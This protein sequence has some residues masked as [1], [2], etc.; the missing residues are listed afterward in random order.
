MR[1]DFFS[2]FLIILL[3]SAFLPSVKSQPQ[4]YLKNLEKNDTF[5]RIPTITLKDSVVTYIDT[6]DYY[7]FNVTLTKPPE[8]NILTFPLETN[9]LIFYYQPPLNE[10]WSVDGTH[11]D[12]VNATH[13]LF[14]GTVVA[15]R[16]E[17]V[18]GSYAVYR[19]DGKT[20]GIYNTGKL[21]HIYTPLIIDAE[22]KKVW[23]ELKLTKT[24]LTVSIDAKF[25][26]SAIY[27]VVVDPTFGYTSIGGSY[28]G[29][30][31]SYG[32]YGCKFTSPSDIDEITS[33]TVYTMA[34]SAGTSL[35]ALIYSDNAGAPNA[36][37][38]TFS[39]ETVP[40]GS[41]GWVT[42]AGSFSASPATVYWLAILQEN[43][44][45]WYYDSGAS[46]QTAWNWDDW[47]TPSD[48]YGSSTYR[49][50]KISIYATYTTS[51][52]ANYV[53]DLS[54]SVSSSWSLSPQTSFHTIHAQTITS[55]W[56]LTHQWNVIVDI[57]QS[58]STTWSI[59]SN[60]NTF[61]DLSSSITSSW[62]F[63]SQW[64]ALLDFA[65]YIEATWN[66]LPSWLAH[67]DL[68]QSITSIWSLLPQWTA[69]INF[70]LSLSFSWLL[71]VV[72]TEL[73]GV[74]YTVDLS[75]SVISSW[76][77]SLQWNALVSLSQS[78]SSTWNVLAGWNANVNLA[79]SLTSSW[80][81]DAWMGTQ[82]IADL[83]L[84]VISSWGIDLLH[85]V[86]VNLTTIDEVLAIAV[87]ALICAIALPITFWS[88]KRRKE[89]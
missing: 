61:V 20:G 13:A 22:G 15:F 1:K 25:L 55:A 62:A 41:P 52:G 72:H 48:P 70:D 80:I 66:I 87:F 68:T 32:K 28:V 49:A 65:Q 45:R 42:A 89:D 38:A 56:A 24:S 10:E 19:E 60:T 81:V 74:A 5:L 3:A 21:Y 8:T 27:P 59:L 46:N 9:G 75:L 88:I 82:Y 17:N 16:P 83:T 36:L 14:K 78:I 43:V 51:G 64:T 40:S 84:A 4:S 76:L 31:N 18:V 67:I 47:D 35:K 73:S 71:D 6:K 57:S 7:Q 37:L 33:I 34:G 12:F 53:A 54:Q 77:T 11:I 58:T 50:E 26:D 39:T 85:S 30:G 44:A 63:L 79:L 69:N 86:G 2:F 29:L 23:G